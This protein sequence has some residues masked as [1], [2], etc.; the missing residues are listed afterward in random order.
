MIGRNNS[1]RNAFSPNTTKHIV[2]QSIGKN[3]PLIEPMPISALGSD[4]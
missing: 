3:S 2:A 4:K 1:R